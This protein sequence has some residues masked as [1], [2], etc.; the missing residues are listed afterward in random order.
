MSDL[1]EKV[2]GSNKDS[3]VVPSIGE[4]IDSRRQQYVESLVLIKSHLNELVEMGCVRAHI[5]FKNDKKTMFM[6]LPA[7]GFGQRKY[8]H[9]GVNPIKQKEARDKVYR[10][11]KRN[12]ISERLNNLNCKIRN[13][14]RQLDQL[15]WEYG[16]VVS[17]IEKLH[18]V[19]GEP[20]E[21]PIDIERQSGT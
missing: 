4:V 15:L 21:A 1:Y 17:D 12:R 6:N 8:I 3:V 20:N 18:R 2:N 9:V 10:E 14:D 7:D 5:H 13:L 19:C 16:R 11:D